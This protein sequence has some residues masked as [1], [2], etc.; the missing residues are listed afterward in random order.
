[1]SIQSLN[2]KVHKLETDLAQVRSA[3]RY[4]WGQFYEKQEEH[5]ILQTETY[6]T[7]KQFKDKITEVE[8]I[9]IHIQNEYKEMCGLLKKKLDCPICLDLIEPNQLQISSCGHKYCKDCYSHIDKCAICRKM[10]KK[11]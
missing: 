9:P 1:M 10:L 6:N 8:T 4:A 7:I 3:R 2:R 11:N 5:Y